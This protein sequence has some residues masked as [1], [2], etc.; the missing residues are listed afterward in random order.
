MVL[1][2]DKYLFMLL[3]VDDLLQTN[4]VCGDKI[5]KNTK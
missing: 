1:N 2:P 5:L 3:G 4:L